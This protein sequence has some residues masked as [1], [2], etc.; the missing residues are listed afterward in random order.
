MDDPGSI[1]LGSIVAFLL[2]LIAS[3]YFSGTETSLAS[4]NRIHMITES[5]KG[6][7]RA[8]RVLYIL[9][10]FEE[11][12]S[13]LLIGNN[14]VNI[15]CAT[16]A[17]VI[18]TRAFGTGSLVLSLTTVITTVVIYMFG[19]SI[20]KIFARS[21]NE[22]FAMTASGILM[23]L[24]RILK[25]FSAFFAWLSK[26][27]TKPFANR[28][29]ADIT[30]TEEE[31]HDMVKNISDDE[32]FDEDTGK[33]MK[34]VLE[35][36]DRTAAEIMVPWEKV[37]K[38]PAGTKTAAILDIVRNTTHSRIPVLGRDGNVKGILQIRN[39][40]RAY[41]KSNGHVLLASVTDYPYFVKDTTRIDDLLSQ[42]S[43]HR[44]NLAVVKTEGGKTVGIV[45][46]E[47]ILE[48]L[49]GEIYD[50]E[51]IGGDSDE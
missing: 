3:A 43:N 34:S 35:F 31:L 23:F 40:L 10:H 46:I 51:D 36:D 2:L 45:T 15:G 21:C 39:F 44:R 25:P 41:S 22:S 49:V 9:D 17:V 48:E 20:P 28:T 12:L 13:T 4:V 30:V 37:E 29:A 14:I 50:E 5:D 1:P 26:L 38:I 42:M 33:L 6:N 16:L 7:R 32:N 19:E 11:A 24:M 8:A 27:A 47:D 18:A